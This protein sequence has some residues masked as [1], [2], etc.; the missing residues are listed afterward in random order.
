MPET[1]LTYTFRGDVKIICHYVPKKGSVL[2][3]NEFKTSSKV[4]ILV[5]QRYAL[6]Y[7]VQGD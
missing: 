4:N 5:H 7:Q 1:N 3:C 6:T 2:N